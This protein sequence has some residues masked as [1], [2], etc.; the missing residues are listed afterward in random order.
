MSRKAWIDAGGSEG[1][2]DDALETEFLK[3]DLQQI[4]A[5]LSELAAGIKALN[6]KL[7]SVSVSSTP[8]V[9]L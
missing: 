5:V 6:D 1:D 9:P 8:T 3:E 2:I 7:A 4:P